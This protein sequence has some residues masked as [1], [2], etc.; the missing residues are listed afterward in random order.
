MLENNEIKKVKATSVD[1]LKAYIPIK[2]STI[3][4]IATKNKF[5]K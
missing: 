5:I 2:N 3:D 4:C 1:T